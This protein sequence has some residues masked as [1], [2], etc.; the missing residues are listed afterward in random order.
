MGIERFIIFEDMQALPPEQKDN[1]PS[2]TMHVLD[3]F[4]E[5]GLVQVR[6]VPSPAHP[7]FTPSL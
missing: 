6:M 1:R 5:A 2:H 7:N 3:P 4:V